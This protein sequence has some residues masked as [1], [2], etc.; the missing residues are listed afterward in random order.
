MSVYPNVMQG[1]YGTPYETGAKRKYPL[2]QRLESPNGRV[3][4]YAEMGATIGVSNKLYQSEVP[5]SDFKDMLITTATVADTTTQLSY[6]LGSTAQTRDM[7][8]D[9]YVVFTELNDL[10][11]VHQIDRNDVAAASGT[12][13]LYLKPGDLFQVAV[14]VAAGNVITLVKNPYKDIILTISTAP[15]AMPVGIPPVII[16]ANA[17]GWVQTHGVASCLIDGTVVIG[18]EGRASEGTAGAIAANDYDEADDANI[19]SLCRII[20]VAPTA[21]FGGVFLT[22]EGLS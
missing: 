1:S 9:G 10:G 5:S 2:G 22:L 13:T 15:T 14:A 3:W 17:Y 12:G 6:T 20:E 11:E 7:F 18:Q 21:T 8:K 16:A 19:G 4:R